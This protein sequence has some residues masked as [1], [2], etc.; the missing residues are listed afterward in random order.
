[1]LLRI[2]LADQTE[3]FALPDVER[4]VATALISRLRVRYETFRSRTR[5]RG[6]HSLVAPVYCSASFFAQA[7]GEQVRPTDQRVSPAWLH[8]GARRLIVM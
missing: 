6:C 5:E 1:M 4:H 3:T 8:T 2:R 7:V